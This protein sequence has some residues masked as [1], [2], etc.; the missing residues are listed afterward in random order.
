MSRIKS[1]RL[2]NIS[3]LSSES[4]I[5]PGRLTQKIDGNICYHFSLYKKSRVE[6]FDRSSLKVQQ[7]NL[8]RAP[9][10]LRHPQVKVH[11][12]VI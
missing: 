12:S 2:L 5:E 6:A 1:K 10:T 11:N 4:F 7:N 8:W 3:K 9:H